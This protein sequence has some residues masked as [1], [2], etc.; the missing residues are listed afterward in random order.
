MVNFLI[1]IL[2]L[3]HIMLIILNEPKNAGQERND[4]FD[5]LKSIITDSTIRI[6]EKNKPRR[7]AENVANFIFCTNNASPVKIE[8]SDHHYIVTVCNDRYMGDFNYFKRLCGSFT[9]Q[10]YS[11]LLSY[12][13]QHDLSNF[14]GQ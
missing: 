1:H 5:A 12:F 14:E 6:N 3:Q 9:P 8:A 10:F 13:I 7:T 2:K 4:N 11:Y